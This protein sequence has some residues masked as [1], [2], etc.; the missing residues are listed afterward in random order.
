MAVLLEEIDRL[1][2]SVRNMG[3]L[4]GSP[5]IPEVQFRNHRPTAW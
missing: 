3:G 2:G 4:H 1:C 5:D